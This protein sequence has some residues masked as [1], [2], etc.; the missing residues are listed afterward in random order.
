[1][2]VP[3]TNLAER[4]ALI[5]HEVKRRLAE[6]G[7][8]IQVYLHLHSKPGSTREQISKDLELTRAQAIDSLRDLW[9]FGLIEVDDG[10][11]F[12]PVPIFLAPV[13]MAKRWSYPFV[14]GEEP[15]Y[16]KGFRLKRK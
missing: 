15:P 12:Y 5:G 16:L 11:R 2:S 4:F 1:M 8:S 9:W 10:Y 7:E 6:S 13:V 3:G 14:F